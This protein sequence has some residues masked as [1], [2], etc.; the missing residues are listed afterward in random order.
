MK[1]LEQ[2]CEK[3]VELGLDGAKRIDPH[4]VLTAEWVKMK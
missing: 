2:Y 4:S 3:A 1:S